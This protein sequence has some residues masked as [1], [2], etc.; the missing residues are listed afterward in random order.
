THIVPHYFPNY[1]GTSS[2]V[3]WP[4]M[5][6]GSACHKHVM[7]EGK[8]FRTVAENA[9]N[10]SVRLDDMAHDEVKKQVLSPMPE[11]LSYWLAPQDGQQMARFLNEYISGMVQAQPDRFYG[12]GTV[13][14]QDI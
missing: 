6:E 8:V 12:L 2:N 4:S 5:K 7:L 9:W 13:A 1:V 10:T 14:L 11:L 3:R